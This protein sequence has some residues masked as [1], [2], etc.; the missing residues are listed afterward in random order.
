MED[1][2]FIETTKITSKGQATIPKTVR[3]IIGVEP[4][5]KISFV[6]YNDTVQVVNANEFTKAHL[7]GKD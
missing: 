4:G 5:D 3:E 6:V 7:P 1:S 2:A